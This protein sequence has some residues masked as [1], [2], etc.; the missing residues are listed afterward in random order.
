[1]TKV[2]WLLLGAF[3]GWFADPLPVFSQPAAR[4]VVRRGRRAVAPRFVPNRYMVFLEE[5]PVASRY[6]R[7]EQMETSAAS[8]YRAL[9]QASQRNLARELAARNILVTGSADT[10]LNAIFVVAAPDRVAELRG[11]PGV[12]GVAPERVVRK[13]LNKATALAN[14]PAAWASAAIGGPSNAGSGIKIA[15]L[16]TGIDQNHPAFQDASLIVPPGFP[17]CNAPS[18]CQNFTNNKVIV[19]RSYV[20]QIAA[21]SACA[22]PTLAGC[23]LGAAAAPNPATSSPDDYSARDRDGHGTFVAAAAAANQNSAGSMAFSGVAP[24]AYL[25]SYKI[26]GS[27]GVN[28]APPESVWIQALED[29]LKDGMDIVNMS[30]G[31]TAFTGALDTAA[32]GNPSGVPCDP[33]AAA[34]EAA[35]QAGLVIT[36]AVGDSGDAAYSAGEYYPNFNSIMSPATAPSVIGVG[37]T[38]NSHVLGSLVSVEAANAPSSLKKHRR[39]AQRFLFRLR[40]GHRRVLCFVRPGGAAGGCHRSGR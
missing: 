28:D 22:Q 40:H 10:L 25:G 30:S 37:A 12:L 39:P 38:L 21:Q 36:V 20:P 34:F 5:P 33:L 24:K 14:A 27:P 11:L 8:A 15:I 4:D 7:R 31:T 13:N 18:D 16:D 17:K 9:V 1:M 26:W 32:C 35:A 2:S 23:N 3:L 19:A 6:G 29:A